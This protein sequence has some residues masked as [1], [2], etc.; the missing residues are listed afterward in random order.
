MRNRSGRSSVLL[1]LLLSLTGCAPRVVVRETSDHGGDQLVTLTR[2]YTA[3]QRSLGRPPRGVDD[4]KAVAKEFGDLD[5]LLK[6]PNDGQPYAIAWG[7]DLGN[8]P[9]PTM[10]V[11]HEKIGAGG[12]R[13]VMTP[14]GVRKLTE[15]AFARAEF[16]P[17]YKPPAP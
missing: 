5:T 1:A 2:V 3:A 15:E 12:V 14:T 6:S 10:V 7:V 9:N 11:A 17:G 16:P 8:A 4:L 13:Y